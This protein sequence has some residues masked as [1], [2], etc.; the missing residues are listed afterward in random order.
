MELLKA[1]LEKINWNC[2]SRNPSIFT[3]EF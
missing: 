1:N 2:L 3:D